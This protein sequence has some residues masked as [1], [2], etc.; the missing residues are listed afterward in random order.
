MRAPET[1]VRKLMAL[2][3]HG[4][5]LV[6]SIDSVDGLAAVLTRLFADLKAE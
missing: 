4:R 2:F 1:L 5:P 6:Q 3:N